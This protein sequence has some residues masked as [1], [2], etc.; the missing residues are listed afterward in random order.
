MFYVSVV[1]AW[2]SFLSTGNDVIGLQRYN[3]IRKNIL[4]SLPFLQP[5]P[6][7][8]PRGAKRGSLQAHIM[9]DGRGMM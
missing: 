6:T 3:F 2:K 5:L 7:A 9:V 4:L 1:E 8:R